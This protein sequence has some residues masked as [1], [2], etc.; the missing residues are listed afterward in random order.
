MYRTQQKHS[1]KKDAVGGFQRRNKSG[2]S[3]KGSGDTAP[4]VNVCGKKKVGAF[5]S[6]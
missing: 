2:D 4:Q 5:R 6:A 1:A 3:A